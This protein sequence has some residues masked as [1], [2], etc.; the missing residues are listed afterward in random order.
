MGKLK[1]QLEVDQVGPASQLQVGDRF[2]FT[3]RRDPNQHEVTQDLDSHFEYDGR[4]NRRLSKDVMVKRVGEPN[5]GERTDR[6]V[7]ALTA[8]VKA[9]ESSGDV[10]AWTVAM[11]D[12]INRAA[13]SGMDDAIV[14]LEKLEK[15]GSAVFSKARPQHGK[16]AVDLLVP[17]VRKRW[18]ADVGAAVQVIRSSLMENVRRVVRAVLTGV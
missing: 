6:A 7:T 14:P 2:V 17:A 9:L 11:T 5:L 13:G 16:M 15:Q 3:D 1:E 12:V 4:V 8:A 18:S 10:Q